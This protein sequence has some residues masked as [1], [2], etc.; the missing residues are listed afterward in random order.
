M[1]RAM[2]GIDVGK[3]RLDVSVD[4]GKVR[5]FA[6]T[7]AG[8]SELVEWLGSWEEPLAI[9]EATGGYELRL[10]EALRQTGTP[11]HI[12]HPNQV[13]DFARA[14]G[15]QAKTDG[16]DAMVLSRYGRVFQPPA[17]LAQDADRDRLQEL[18]GR[19]DQLVEQRT[20]EKNRLSQVRRAGARGSIER[21]IEWLDAEIGELE[22]EYRKL[23]GENAEFRRQFE[24]Y[25]SV[26][27]VGIQT[28]ATLIAWLPELGHWDGKPLA[29]LCGVAPWS[30][31]SGQKRGYRATRGGRARVRRV[32]Y[33]ASLSV[34]RSK[35]GLGACYDRLRQRGKPGKVA[36]VAIMRKL[37]LQLNAV[38]RRGTPWQAVPQ[39]YT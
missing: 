6:N 23:L 29:S 1:S 28:A 20:Q 30:R 11:V 22:G 16:L 17:T 5:P 12:A 35:V 34:S 39:P 18:L 32:L 33:L 8:V 21:H 14:C 3:R 4:E 15:Y 24:L 38:A 36:L 2:A 13:R 9:C 25:C 26:P 7:R 10:V 19:R 27:G 31:D 37:L